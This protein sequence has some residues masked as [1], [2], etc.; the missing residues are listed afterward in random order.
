M[1]S[2][3]L[4]SLSLT[5][6]PV[7]GY[8]FFCVCEDG[9]PILGFSVNV[10]NRYFD[11]YFP[12]AIATSQA[13]RANMSSSDRY[14]WMT[15]SWLV[16]YYLD[17]PPGMGLHCP[18]TE[19]QQA[20]K[21]AVTRGDIVW[22]AW[23]FNSQLEMCDPAMIDAGLQLTHQLDT[24]LNRPSGPSSVLSQRDV[25]GTTRS[26]IPRLVR[27]GIA[28]I[29]FGVN[30]FSSPPA[31]FAPL[32]TNQ[33]FE[34]VHPDT[35]DSVIVMIHGGG[36][37]GLSATADAVLTPGWS[38]ALIMD[39]RG[40]NAGPAEPDEVYS[41][42]AT[43]REQFPNAKNIH[44]ST[45][46]A[47]VA[48]LKSALSSSSTSTSSSSPAP[49]PAPI[50]ALPKFSYEIGD[51]WIHGITSDPLKQAQFRA[52]QHIR[53]DCLL[54]IPAGCDHT[55][56]AFQNFTRFLLKVSEHTDGG[57]VKE[58]LNASLPESPYYDWSNPVFDQNRNADAHFA[59]ME[60]SWHEQRDWGIRYAVDA[61]PATHAMR[62]RIEQALKELMIP[63]SEYPDPVAEGF[64]MA[65][66]DTVYESGGGSGEHRYSLG[67]SSKNG[68]LS[69]L[70]DHRRHHERDSRWS[71]ADP[72]SVST[73]QIGV[74][75]Y[76]S[77]NE[78]DFLEYITGYG[79]CP[80]SA[81]SYAKYDFGKPGVNL[82]ANPTT[83][84]VTATP[85]GLWLKNDSHGHGVQE[86]LLELMFEEPLTSW[87]GAP[88]RVWVRVIP[89]A[90][91]IEMSVV[92]F[93][94]TVTRLPEALWFQFNP[95]APAPPSSASSSSSA[96]AD[97]DTEQEP[98]A[99]ANLKWWMDKT[100]SVIDIWDIVTNGSSHMH[101]VSRD[102]G[103]LAQ[104]QLA[105]GEQIRIT[106]R[107]AP[108]AS[109]GRISPFPL[110]LAKTVDESTRPDTDGYGVQYLLYTNNWGTNYVMWYPF[111][112]NDRNQL[113]R[114]AINFDL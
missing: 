114:F 66:F 104:S 94:K 70:I 81:C 103:V 27:N 3:Q 65:E 48:E 37:G 35:G 97:E 55:S 77:F 56:Y 22:H 60:A 78:T 31:F 41:N 108:V 61:L 112:P 71:W 17:C 39:W 20:F 32:N 58:F 9:I 93:N 13:M 19:Q 30:S 45:F 10:V 25:P 40:D 53:S 2:S 109:F 69:T 74:F 33:P 14:I 76:Q 4:L 26:I 84:T 63:D 16:S 67:F 47:F 23:P 59:Q 64:S 101:V 24:E 99:S 1:L 51:T 5:C 95:K 79:N 111:D 98:T 106:S 44:A 62:P 21:D 49:A 105:L 46:D 100:G 57:D 34:W 68:G 102:G 83:Q 54:N 90:T 86:F 15:Q 89:L 107:D 36:Y 92:W 80:L 96:A 72:V 52:V 43:L 18:T 73:H 7:P 85:V 75:Q 38:T 82:A 91:H 29:S 113:F 6:S 42:F 8:C 50:P 87:Y 88:P 11:V 110:P 28:A 12:R